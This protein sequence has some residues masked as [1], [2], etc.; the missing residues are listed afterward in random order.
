MHWKKKK[1]SGVT[2]H[3]DSSLPRQLCLQYLHY[4]LMAVASRIFPYC[5]IQFRAGSGFCYDQIQAW[6][7]TSDAKTL[8]QNYLWLVGPHWSWAGKPS[9]SRVNVWQ[10]PNTGIAGRVK[11]FV[12]MSEC[13]PCGVARSVPLY[14][15]DAG[16]P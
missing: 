3:K 4:C 10:K 12:Q 8:T 9:P 7:A 16:S 14:P 15:V 13:C 5:L 11:D 1:K 6:S 2:Y